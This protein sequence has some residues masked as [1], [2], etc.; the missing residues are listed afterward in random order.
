MMGDAHLAVT[1]DIMARTKKRVKLKAVSVSSY[2]LINDWVCGQNRRSSE[3]QG[4]A[5]GKCLR[6]WTCIYRTMPAG[7]VQ[8]RHAFVGGKVS[9]WGR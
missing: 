4:T 5:L 7:I 2:L 1:P 9:M 8:S 3:I 6:A